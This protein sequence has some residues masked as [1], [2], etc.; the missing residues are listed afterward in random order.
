M[1]AGFGPG[2]Y[3]TPAG[4]YLVRGSDRHGWSQVFFPRY[5]WIDVEATPG[6]AGPGR[7]VPTPHLSARRPMLGIPSGEEDELLYEEDLAALEELMRQARMRA[8]RAREEG[9]GGW[10]VVPVATGLGGAAGILVMAFLVWRWG[11]R[12]MEPAERAYARVTRLGA[13]LGAGRPAHYTPSEYAELLSET[14]PTLA[15]DITGI[16]ARYEA[17]VYGR[18][19]VAGDEGRELERRWRR[20]RGAMVRWRLR[21]L[22]PR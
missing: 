5:G 11:L 12:G 7:G 9:A 6:G 20:V 18:A 10:P 22:L 2:E 3:T 4:A 8:S 16:V 15:E 1:V 21:N 19:H 17:E 14:V 13:L